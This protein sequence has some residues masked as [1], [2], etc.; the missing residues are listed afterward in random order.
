MTTAKQAEIRASR[1]GMGFASNLPLRQR[2]HQ[3]GISLVELI[4]FIVIISVGLAGI[5]LVMDT[6]TKSS[7]DPLIHKQALAIA[8]S[9]LE[10][11]QLQPFTFCD[12]ND[13]LARSAVAAASCTGGANGPNDESLL[14]LGPE[15]AA[16]VGGAEGRYATPHFDNVNDYNGFSMA[17]GS[18]L[19]IAG[20]A[21][22]A[23][24]STNITVEQAALD[25]VPATDSLLITVTVTG[26]D[27]VP[28]VLQGY[29]TRY[30]PNAF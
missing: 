13:P 24:Y 26:P 25:V 23:G 14:P 27:N 9:L 11:V 20:G 17:A 12:P 6:T 8:E 10:E 3:R 22:V 18:V 19:D 16:S 4:I 1:V 5:L 7:A 2:A 28:V 29:R 15:T 21:V 30:A